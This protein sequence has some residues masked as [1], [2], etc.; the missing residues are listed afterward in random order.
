MGKNTGRKN[1]SFSVLCLCFL[2]GR[3]ESFSLSFSTTGFLSLLLE[4]NEIDPNRIK[5][6]TTLK[7]Q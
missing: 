2:G 1:G 7:E 6:Q 5:K 4:L 3:F